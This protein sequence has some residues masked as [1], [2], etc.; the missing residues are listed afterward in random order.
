MTEAK[1]GG[2]G[3]GEGGQVPIWKLDLTGPAG[4]LDWGGREVAK[5][6]PSWGLSNRR[7]GTAVKKQIISSARACEWLRK[8]MNGRL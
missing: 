3:V 5:G 6:D 2:L 4:R 7:N 8:G 1:S